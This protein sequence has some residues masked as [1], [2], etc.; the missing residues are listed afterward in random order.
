[1]PEHTGDVAY[2]GKVFNA[3]NVPLKGT[4]G[5]RDVVQ[6]V[7]TSNQEAHAQKLREA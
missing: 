4:Q 2:T 6:N 1:M 7:E 5:L 3:R